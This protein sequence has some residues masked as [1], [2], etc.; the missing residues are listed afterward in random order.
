MATH[1]EIVRDAIK[2]KQS[3]CCDYKGYYREICPH[4]MGLKGNSRRV[5]VYQF[6]GTSSSGP[7][8]PEAVDNWRCLI[9]DGMENVRP[10]EAEWH[11]HSPHTRPSNAIDVMEFEIDH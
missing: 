7:I 1:Y 8:R 4:A 9:L 10:I 2:S 6:G 5:L 3:L 11:S